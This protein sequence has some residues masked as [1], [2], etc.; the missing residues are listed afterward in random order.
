MVAQQIFVPVFVADNAVAQMNAFGSILCP[1]RTQN[2]ITGCFLG[3]EIVTGI[4]MIG[5]LALLNVEKMIQKEQVEIKV[6]Y[7]EE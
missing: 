3:M 6:R 1:K 5:L 7:S 2:A 4:I